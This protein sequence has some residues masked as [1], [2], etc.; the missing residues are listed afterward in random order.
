MEARVPYFCID[1]EC[2]ASSK[3]HSDRTPIS[4]AL[5]N[6]K[7]QVIFQSFV[8]PNVTV[9]NYLTP[10][11]GVTE[12]DMKEARALEDVVQEIRKVVNKSDFL[13]ILVGAG[14]D[15]DIRWIGLE[16]GKDYSDVIDLA[17]MFKAWNPKYGQ[18]NKF[19]LAHLCGQLLGAR[20][21]DV[22][23]P[24]EDAVLSIR[25]Y[26]RYKDDQNMLDRARNSMIGKRAPDNFV[27][28]NNYQ[29]QGVC[30]AG[31]YPEKCICGAPTNK[32]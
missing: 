22:H 21:G 17:E 13:P 3:L 14:I 1:V 4:I 18:Y 25:L 26:N 23:S 32:Q 10:L 8:R 15:N 7:E 2:A 6:E 24:S 28:R 27:K 11:T 31:Y 19:S 5:V 20:I 30:M 29:Y 9:F 16:K 12:K